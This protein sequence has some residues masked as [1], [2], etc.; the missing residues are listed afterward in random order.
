M[1]QRRVSYADQRAA[2]GLVALLLLAAGLC[3]TYRRYRPIHG[4]SQDIR[5][6]E[7][8]EDGHRPQVAVLSGTAVTLASALGRLTPRKPAHELFP[9]RVLCRPL[10]TGERLVISASDHGPWRVKVVPMGAR[11]LLTVGKRLDIN[12]AAFKDLLLVPRMRVSLARS[13]IG[14]RPWRRLDDLRRISGIGPKTVERWRRYLKV[15]SPRSARTV[16]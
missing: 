8:Q 9:E 15:A 10:H 13:I 5:I 1:V 4:G 16:R 7:I 6:V 14:G 2:L 12:G 11:S 3:R